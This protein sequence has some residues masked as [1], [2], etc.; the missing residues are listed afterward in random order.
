MKEKDEPS[1]PVTRINSV[2]Q[3]Q[4]KEIFLETLFFVLRDSWCIA[5]I[6]C[7]AAIVV[8]HLESL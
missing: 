8:H 6:F 3:W 7:S 5:K 2:D 1:N 4:A